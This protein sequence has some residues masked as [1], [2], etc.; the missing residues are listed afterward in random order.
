MS[1]KSIAGVLFSEDR[2]HV[3][4]ILRRDVPV[5]VLPGGGVDSGETPEE[6]LV[7]EILEETGLCVKI[8]RCVGAYLPINR[9]SRPTLLYE[10]ESLSGE[11]STSSETRAVRFWPIDHLPP[12]PPPYEEWISDALANG[13]MLEKHLTSVTYARLLKEAL[14]HPLLVVR[15]LLSR[16]G[17][18][19]N[20]K[21]VL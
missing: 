2:T 21:R 20:S 5:W 3:L 10:C 16:L 9:L 1:F 12:L 6:A 8:R 19:I 7:R 13:P 14:L 18:P 4:L 11:L 15:F 17:I